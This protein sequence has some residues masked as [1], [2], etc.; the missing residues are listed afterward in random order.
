MLGKFL[1]LAARD[2]RLLARAAVFLIAAKIALRMTSV[3]DAR[4]ALARFLAAGRRPAIPPSPER[5]T[6]AVATAGRVIPGL[7]N[8]LLQALAAEAFLARAGY[9]CRLQIGAAKDGPHKL[10]A[11]AWLER[12][13]R[14]LLGDFEPARFRKLTTSEL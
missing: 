4:N 7:R 12:D 11:H 2:W 1:R 9:D 5:I 8:C 13:G 14:I 6:W 3:A 10:V